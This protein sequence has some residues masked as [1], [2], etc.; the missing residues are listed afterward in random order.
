MVTREIGLRAF[1][2]TLNSA[3]ASTS[4][5]L[6]YTFPKQ[7]IKKWQRRTDNKLFIESMFRAHDVIYETYLFSY[8]CCAIVFTHSLAL[9]FLFFSGFLR[10]GLSIYLKLRSR[11]STPFPVGRPRSFGEIYMP[12]DTRLASQNTLKAPK[13][14][15]GHRAQPVLHGADIY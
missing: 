10:L 13:E 4:F 6:S 2:P 5:I 14:R 12:S 1:T 8:L 3:A 9:S 7:R 15:D 11:S